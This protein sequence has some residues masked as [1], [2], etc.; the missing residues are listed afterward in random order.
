MSYPPSK[1]V[2]GHTLTFAAGAFVDPDR[3]YGRRATAER[4]L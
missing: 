2:A 3:A 4:G 1:N